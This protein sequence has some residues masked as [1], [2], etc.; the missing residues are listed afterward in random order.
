MLNRAVRNSGIGILMLGA[1]TGAAVLAL[2]PAHA[3]LMSLG[4]SVYVANLQQLNNS[5]ASGTA[6]I[7]MSG[8]H[9]TLV[10]HI[11]ARGLERGGPH[12]SHIHGLSSNGHPVNST[13][14]TIAQDSDH[15]GY[16][17]LAEGQQTYG[18]ILVDFMNVDPDE[19]GYVD[20]RKVIR[21]TGSEGVL[22]LDDRHIVIHGMTVGP[23][24]RGTPGE[25]DGTAGDKVVLPVLCG[26]LKRAR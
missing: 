9:R 12:L 11:V 8:D 22:P 6:E 4:S 17:E 14:P 16:V 10:V 21:L 25:V 20:F 26:E 18:P 15:D 3:Q 5:H 13:C 1:A 24:G 23:V 7:V 2:R 19:N